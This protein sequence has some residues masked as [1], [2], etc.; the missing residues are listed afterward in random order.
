VETGSSTGELNTSLSVDIGS[1]LLGVGG[2]GKNNIGELGTS[3]TVVTL[4]DDESTLGDVL[5]GDLVSSKKPD[6][7]GDGLGD[8]GV[9]GNETDIVGGSAG[10]SLEIVSR[11]S[12][13]ISDRTYPLQNVVSVPL[14]GDELGVVLLQELSNDLVHGLGVNVLSD[15]R[16]HDDHGTLSSQQLLSEISGQSLLK[17]GGIGS[18]VLV[19]EGTLESLSDETDLEVRAQPSLADSSVENGSLVTGVGSDQKDGISLLDSVDARVEEVVGTDVNSVSGGKG[20]VGLVEGE[21]LRSKLV[22]QVL[23]GNERLGLDKVS[24]NGLDLVTLGG[25]LLVGSGDLSKSLLPGSG[26]ELVVLANQGG[27]QTLSAETITG[28]TGLVVD[29]LLV[30]IVVQAGKDTHD[31][32]TTNIDTD[33]GSKSV[34]NVDGLNTLKLPGTSTESV[35]L[36]SQG[37]D[38]AKVD[39]VSG[40]LRVEVAFKVGSDLYVVSTS[41]RS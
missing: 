31:L 29:P 38:G 17:S 21:V 7:L 22:H 5:G 12:I 13:I 28:E 39:D 33:V 27:G 2:S 36:G 4:V 23:Q 40:E 25:E 35:G 34:K 6:N 19:L 37:S 18:K 15:T 8:G 14:R 3:V 32:H 10:C 24:G 26:L 41:G 20:S 1:G 11:N 30:D 16:S 9:G